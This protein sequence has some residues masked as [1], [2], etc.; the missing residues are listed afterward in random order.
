MEVIVNSLPQVLLAMQN[1]Y[2]FEGVNMYDHG[3]MV[4]KE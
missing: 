2:Q 4:N 3:L 1:C